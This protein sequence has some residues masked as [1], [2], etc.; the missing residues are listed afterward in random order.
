MK[1]RITNR[2]SRSET[3]EL[4]LQGKR[5][6]GGSCGQI[7]DL[8]MFFSSNHPRGSG[9]RFMC[10]ECEAAYHNNY[11]QTVNG[12]LSQK[13]TSIKRRAIH[14]DE[15]REIA[16]VRLYGI[17][18]T[19]KIEL[20]EAQDKKCAICGS[21][22]ETIEKAHLDHD[23]TSK[24][25]RGILCTR[26]NTGLGLFHDNIEYLQKAITYWRFN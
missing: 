25:I 14:K 26:C 23:H 18:H 15:W 12:K 22:I 21:S 6:C 10:K 24:K 11:L 7:K 20:W 13:A 19:Q 3:K 8:S 16:Y 9:Y 4:L 17:T 1:T 2:L 5:R